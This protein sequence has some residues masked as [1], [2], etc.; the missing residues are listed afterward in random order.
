M[1]KPARPGNLPTSFEAFAMQTF[2]DTPRGFHVRGGYPIQHKASPM[3]FGCGLAILSV[4]L[5][6][7]Y[8]VVL[9]W[10]FR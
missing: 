9:S 1:R 2:S 8:L 6:I 7:L 3:S 4:P 5:A 10:L